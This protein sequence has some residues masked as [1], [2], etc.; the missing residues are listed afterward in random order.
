[1]LWC[2]YRELQEKLDCLQKNSFQRDRT[3]ALLKQKEKEFV[4]VQKDSEALRSQVTSLLGELNERQNWLAKSEAEKRMLEEKWVNL[5]QDLA[6]WI[7][8]I[9]VTYI[10]IKKVCCII[11]DNETNW[12][13]INAKSLVL[14]DGYLNIWVT[15]RGDD[16]RCIYK[17]YRS[18][19]IDTIHMA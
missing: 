19:A 3:E 15:D 6:K 18:L 8:L 17:I 10:F 13:K 14:F 4:Q 12:L 11:L 16:N 2:R 5:F 7:N 9:F 1:M